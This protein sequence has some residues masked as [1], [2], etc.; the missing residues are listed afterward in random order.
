MGMTTLIAGREEAD[1]VKAPLVAS[2]L[3]ICYI[4]MGLGFFI[5]LAL[6][7]WVENGCKREERDSVPR[8][9]R[10]LTYFAYPAAPFIM[11]DKTLRMWVEKSLSKWTKD[12]QKDAGNEQESKT[13]EAPAKD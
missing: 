1:R 2:Q 10:F 6:M 13:E 4:L 8:C 3:L 5:G 12:K 11:F 9:F 7:K